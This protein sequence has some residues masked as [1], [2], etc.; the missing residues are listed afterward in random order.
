MQEAIDTLDEVA[1]YLEDAISYL[2][3]VVINAESP[4]AM[5]SEP[6]KNLKVGD[7][8]THKSFGSGVIKFIEG[9]RV[10]ID[11]GTRC[12]LFIL[13]DAIDK[14]FIIL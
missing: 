14:G 1:G 6:W 9:N 11:F 2:D 5:E 4:Y 3:E 12:S 8:V 7:S 10:T 13:P